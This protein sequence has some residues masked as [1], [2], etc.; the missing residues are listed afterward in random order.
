MGLTVAKV[1]LDQS[2]LFGDE[3]AMEF[4]SQADLVLEQAAS[5]VASDASASLLHREAHVWVQ[6][7]LGSC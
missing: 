2:L 3:K 1:A 4:L 5:T 6:G 7:A